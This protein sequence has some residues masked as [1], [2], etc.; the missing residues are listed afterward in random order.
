[1]RDTGYAWLDAGLRIVAFLMIAG[2]GLMQAK[3]EGGSRR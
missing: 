1:M 2:A 3:T